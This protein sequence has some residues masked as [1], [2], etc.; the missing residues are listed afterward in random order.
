M[1]LGNFSIMKNT[2]RKWIRAGLETL[3][4]GGAASAASTIT[5][6]MVDPQNFA[7]FS[8][9]SCKMAF[10][11]FAVNGGL[12]FFQWWSNNPLPPDSDTAPPFKDVSSPTISINPLS[13]VGPLVVNQQNEIK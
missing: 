6:T 8:P 2:T 7:L 12:R 1:L 5:A 10:A 9:N 4:H 3:I 11:S 13:K